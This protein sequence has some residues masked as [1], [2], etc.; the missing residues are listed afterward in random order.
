MVVSTEICP[1]VTV[2]PELPDSEST[3]VGDDPIAPGSSA[4]AGAAESPA[5]MSVAAIA[6]PR[7]SPLG[8]F[9][10]PSRSPWRETDADTRRA[11]HSDSSGSIE[12]SLSSG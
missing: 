3:V 7:T 1:E 8:A 9:G 5:T 12:Y 10:D 4:Q 11:S 2:F 6:I